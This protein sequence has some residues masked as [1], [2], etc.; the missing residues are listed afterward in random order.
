M[1]RRVLSSNAIKRD[2]VLFVSSSG[3]GTIQ[4]QRHWV[5]RQKG[6]ALEP[7]LQ[8]PPQQ[9]DLLFFIA[10]GDQ[11]QEL[12][13]DVLKAG[14]RLGVRDLQKAVGGGL[15]GGAEFWGFARRYGVPT[16][17]LPPVF[18]TG[19]GGRLA[20]LVVQYNAL[21]KRISA[22]QTIRFWSGDVPQS[23]LVQLDLPGDWRKF[24]LPPALKDRLQELLDKQD[25]TGKL[26]PRERREA[27][28]LTELVD[29]LALLK[30]RAELAAKKTTA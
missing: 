21:S 22:N 1:G 23:V 3:F 25:Q 20:T 7:I 17:A 6:L 8:K 12:L 19:S 15:P 10:A 29:W 14:G 27:T 28:A 4:A 13:R 9:F 18:D 30:I 11:D 26:S 16:A 24:A 2:A 5:S